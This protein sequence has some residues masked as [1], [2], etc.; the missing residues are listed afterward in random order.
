MKKII[1]LT[2]LIVLKSFA[3]TRYD[4]LDEYLTFITKEQKFMGSVALTEHGKVVFSKNY[5]YE[6]LDKNIVAN[7]NTQYKIGSITKTFTAVLIMRLIEEQRLTLDTKLSTYYKDITNSDKISI[8]DLLHHTSGI[9]NYTSDSLFLKTM[10]K[11]HSKTNLLNLFSKKSASFEP[12]TKNEYSNSNYILLGYI[13]EDITKM[14]YQHNVETKIINRL[15]LKNQDDRD[16]Q[17]N[18]DSQEF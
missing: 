14:S 3:Q 12:G 16:S 1:F 8:N 18:Q 11:K 15:K 9:F 2:L 5:G 17:D 6:N 10:Q 13:I 7:A 4:K